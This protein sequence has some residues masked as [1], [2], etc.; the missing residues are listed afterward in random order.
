MDKWQALQ[1]FWSGFSLPAYDENS[2]PTT[3]TFPYIT[4]AAASGALDEVLNMS[5]SLWYSSTSWAAVSQKAEE[6]SESIAK[7]MPIPLNVGY[8]WITRGDPFAQRMGDPD[9][10]A[11]KRIYINIQAECLTSW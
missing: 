11:I 3:A 7:G 5:A 4:Y 10:P 6:I 8:L 2:V 9:D 1:S